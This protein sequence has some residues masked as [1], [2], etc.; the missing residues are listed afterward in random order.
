MIKFSILIP[1]WD[2]GYKDIEKML[3]SIPNRND[4][5]VLLLDNA[6]NQQ[7]FRKEDVQFSD[8]QF[9]INRITERA[10]VG[11]CRNI[12]IEQA[13]GEWIILAD[14]DDQYFTEQLQLVLD[15]PLIEDYD[16]VYWGSQTLFTDGKIFNDSYGFRGSEIQPL[17]DKSFLMQHRYEAWRKMV[18]RELLIQ[19]PDIRFEDRS[20]YEDIL[21]SIK[22]LNTTK[23]IGVSPRLVYQY[24]KNDTSLLTRR[25][26]KSILVDAMRSVFTAMDIIRENHYSLL[27]QEISK[28]CLIKMKQTSSIQFFKYL[29]VEWHRYGWKLFYRDLVG[30]GFETYE[31]NFFIALTNFLRV[32]AGKLLNATRKRS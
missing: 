18:R 25:F 5:E 12:L 6:S 1:F 7:L 17:T 3:N 20:F 27:G 16:I 30:A 23:K 24:V 15:S 14:A 4:V 2:L 29:F 8:L 11:K 31:T 22:L 21:Y 28:G 13:Q 9:S 32:K 19:N 26:E 10:T